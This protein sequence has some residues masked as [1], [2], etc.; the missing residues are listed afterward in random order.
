MDNFCWANVKKG[1]SNFRCKNKAKKFE[2]INKYCGIHYKTYLKGNIVNFS[3]C[4]PCDIINNFSDSLNIKINNTKREII[5]KNRRNDYFDSLNEIILIQKY[6]RKFIVINNIKVRGSAVYNRK[7]C[8]NDTDFL[9]MIPIDEIPIK[10]FFSFKDKHIWGFNIVSL[11]EIINNNM[12]NPYNTLEISEKV[13]IRFRKLINQI[14]KDR[15][16][17]IKKPVIVD[18]NIHIQQ[19]CIEIFQLMDNLKNYTKCRWFLDLKI[20]QLKELYK[21]MEDIWN[22]RLNLSEDQK[23]KYV[24]DGKLFIMPVSKFYKINDINKLRT[25]LLGNFK[26]MVTEGK[27]DSDKATASQWILSGLTLVNLDARDT[28]PWLFQSANIY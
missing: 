24:T 1:G 15:K 8:N 21:Q 12:N 5:I 7:L 26:K 9:S 4:L 20:L 6:V 2:D 25:I 23:K 18:R 16:I 19:E 17:E 28:L 22:Y 10:D 14:E 27:T 11:K 3:N 13:K